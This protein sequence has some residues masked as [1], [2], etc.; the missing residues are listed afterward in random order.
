MIIIGA[1]AISGIGQLCIKYSHMLGQNGRMYNVHE[2]IPESEKDVFIFALPIEPY[3]QKI[4]ELKKCGKNITCMTICETETVSPEYEKL[5]AVCKG[6][7][8]TTPSQFCK[9]VFQKQFPKYK[10][11]VINAFVPPVHD[12]YVFYHIGNIVDRRKNF[13]KILEAFIRLSLPNSKLIVKATCIKDVNINLPNIEVIN[14]LLSEEDMDK[15]HKRCDCYVS[16]SHSE[17]IGMGAVEAA[18]RNKP[19]IISEYGAASEYIKTPYL[20]SCSITKIGFDD[21]LFTKDLEWGEPNFEQLMTFMKDAY[22]KK[23]RFQDHSHT[24]EVTSAPFIQKQFN[25]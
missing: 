3:I 1:S 10:F 7:T 13:N 19:V 15:I 4:K 23:L 25:S 20:I 22:D 9:T 16:F 14:G 6:L 11:K 17:G 21:F 24:R 18:L 2:D 8:I 12:T 5:F